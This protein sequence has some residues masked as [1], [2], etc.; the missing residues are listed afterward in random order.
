ME[1]L[2]QPEHRFWYNENIVGVPAA[3]MK[4]KREC[5]KE[6]GALDFA[7]LHRIFRPKILR[8]LSGM[9]GEADAEDL[10]QD[11]F[12]KVSRGLRQL[13]GRTRVSTWIYRIATNTAIDHL[14]R[15]ALKTKTRRRMTGGSSADRTDSAAGEMESYPD[16]TATPAETSITENEMLHC[17]RNYIDKLP[18]RQRAVIILSSLEGLKNAEIAGIL[19]VNVQTVKIRLHRGRARLVKEL[20]IHCGWFRDKRNHLTWDG[21]IL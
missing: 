15:P 14:R 8:Y 1:A 13:R 19:G 7:K 6:S 10:V 3:S 17:L 12:I 21:K 2:I 5:P 9:V 11:V 16:E 18:V 4:K 20:E